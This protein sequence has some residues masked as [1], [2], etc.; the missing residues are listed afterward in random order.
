[1]A[2]SA[3]PADPAPPA[4]PKICEKNAQ[5]LRKNTPKT[6]FFAQKMAPIRGPENG[7]HFFYQLYRWSQIRGPDSG[8]RTGTANFSIFRLFWRPGAGFLAAP[9][10]TGGLVPE[11]VQ[12]Q[13]RTRFVAAPDHNPSAGPASHTLRSV[14]LSP[15]PAELVK[16]RIVI[17]A[18]SLVGPLP[19]QSRIRWS[20]PF[21]AILVSHPVKQPFLSHKFASFCEC[22]LASLRCWLHQ[23]ISCVVCQR[24]HLIADLVLRPRR[25][26]LPLSPPLVQK[27]YGGL[28]VLSLNPDTQSCS[29]TERPRKVT[30]TLPGLS[31]ASHTCPC[32]LNLLLHFSKCHR[33]LVQLAL[34]TPLHGPARCQNEKALSAAGLPITRILRASTQRKTLR[35]HQRT[36]AFIHRT[37][38]HN[39]APDNGHALV[40]DIFLSCSPTCACAWRC[41]CAQWMCHSHC[42]S[43]LGEL[44]RSGQD[45]PEEK[46]TPSIRP[47]TCAPIDTGQACASTHTSCA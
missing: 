40:T 22:H 20:Q 3:K 30:S 45:C 17:L 39:M 25:V 12:V 19:P 26:I 9:G 6:G 41:A 24:L 42:T 21:S 47:L 15:R 43:Y 1:M 16:A 8:H 10:D 7:T 32:T 44:S 33:Q 5:K 14:L 27:F 23:E 4:N 46:D 2:E 13:P 18:F 29:H 34:A 37:K 36:T 38:H 11:G 31:T 28:Q 35:S